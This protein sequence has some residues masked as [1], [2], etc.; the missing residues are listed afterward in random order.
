MEDLVFSVE[1]EEPRS[2]PKG[3]EGDL[4]LLSPWQVTPYPIQAFPSGD[5]KWE[6]F[7]FLSEKLQ[8]TKPCGFLGQHLQDIFGLEEFVISCLV[9]ISF[10]SYWY[11]WKL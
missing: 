10:H 7:P 1:F 5:F 8:M 4:Q 3:L 9:V 2:Y 11:S 6:L